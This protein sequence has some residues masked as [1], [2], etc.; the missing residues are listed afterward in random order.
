MRNAFITVLAGTLLLAAPAMAHDD[1][2][3]G[4]IALSQPKGDLGGGK[5]LRG[6]TGASA[7]GHALFDLGD[8]N[9]LCARGDATFF[10]NGQVNLIDS[11]ENDM[12]YAQDAKARVL[13]VSLDYGY[14]F[15]GRP[16]E[17]AYFLLGLGWAWLTLDNAQQ[18]A[19]GVGPPLPAW[20]ASQ[21]AD[22]LQYD[23]GVG[24]RFAPHLASEL[25]FT[26][27]TFR[28][29]AVEGTYCKSPTFS[30]A[31]MMDF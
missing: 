3:G 1:L 20:P 18:A 17:G 21:R 25:R 22:A 2:F 31:L 7:G 9:T 26:Q 5:W 12:L 27:S 4:Q 14:Y 28:S 30:L 19:G 6:R 8:G 24:W 16:T 15:F 29:L 11:G 10:P 23:A 13:A